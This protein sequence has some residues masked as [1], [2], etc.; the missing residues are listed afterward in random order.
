M[1]ITSI[2]GEELRNY[3]DPIGL[4]VWLYGRFLEINYNHHQYPHQGYLMDPSYLPPI[5][6]NPE[7]YSHYF[8]LY[9]FTLPFLQYGY[10][11]TEILPNP[12][13]ETFILFLI[14]LFIR[15]EYWV[16]FMW[17][18]EFLLIFKISSLWC[19]FVTTLTTS[20]QSTSSIQFCFPTSTSLLF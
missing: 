20:T 14:Y 2:K 11:D 8:T 4:V 3:M 17:Y 10:D 7:K 13:K 9:L 5:V 19:S 16:R 1:C 18:V 6:R 12:L 15:R